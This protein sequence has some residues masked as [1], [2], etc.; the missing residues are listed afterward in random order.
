MGELGVSIVIPAL[1]EADNLSAVLDDCA[2][3]RSQAAEVIVVDAGSTDGTRE[4]L[5]ERGRHWSRLRVLDRPDARPGAGRNAGIEAASSPIVV[6]LDSGSRVA[7]DW[8]GALTAPVIEDPAKRCSVGVALP[9][10]RSPFEAAAGGFSVQGFRAPYEGARLAPG[11]TPPGRNGWCFAR[12]SWELAGGYDGSLRWGEDKLFARRLGALGLELVVVHDA[13]VR[14]RP[15][16][17]LG[18]L[19]RQYRGYG[20]GDAVAGLDRGHAL[21][22]LGAYATGGG[23]GIAAARGSRRAAWL[24]AAGASG[25]LA[26]GGLVAAARQ[27]LPARALVWVPPI[28]VAADLAKIHGF[29]DVALGGADQSRK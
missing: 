3:Q 9:D 13:I 10:P 29:L 1:N 23:L 5:R 11:F 19:Y 28:R 20:R 8:L 24:L 6:T 14:W 26:A 2:A 21:L 25:Y 22:P 17:S 4:L 27:G 16:S 15:R 7:P 18:E 12:G